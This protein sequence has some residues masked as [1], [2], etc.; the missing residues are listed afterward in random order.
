MYNLNVNKDGTTKSIIVDSIYKGLLIGKNGLDEAKLEMALESAT[1]TWLDFWGDFYGVFR[2]AKERDA[3]YR[4][5]IIEEIIAPKSTISAIK[6]ATSRHLKTYKNENLDSTDVKVFEP[7]THLIK[8]DERGTLDGKGR[9][10]SYDY[11]NY[12]IIDVSLPESS[13]ITAQLI[14]YLNRIKAGG[15]K[16]VFSL[17]PNWGIVKDPLW[18]EKRYNVWDKGIRHTFILPKRVTSIFNLLVDNWNPKIKDTSIGGILDKHL[19]LDGKQRVFSGGVTLNRSF[20]ATGPLRDYRNSS[21]LSL[22]DYENLLSGEMTLDDAC[23]LEEEAINGSRTN[24]GRLT[25]TQGYIGI[26]TTFD[27]YNRGYVPYTKVNSPKDTYMFPFDNILNYVSYNDI[28]SEVGLTSEIT[29][30]DLYLSLLPPYN[31]QDKS[32]PMAL[33][34]LKLKHIDE[35]NKKESIQGPLIITTEQI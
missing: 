6:R 28:K 20:C 33:L 17:A 31:K 14:K 19:Y 18:D 21:T 3:P 26:S 9:L 25:I 5:R 29:L 16:I 11:W 13:L 15:V 30:N 4:E 12:A 1:G 10:I 24:E 32:I 23:A 35:T 7:W 8:F 22:K 2:I 27:T 34:A